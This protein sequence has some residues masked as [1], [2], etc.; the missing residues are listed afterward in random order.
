MKKILIIVPALIS[1]AAAQTKK[2]AKPAP[3]A[4]AQKNSLT[5]TDILSYAMGL[6]TAKYYKSQGI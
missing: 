1:I 4:V 5:S 3:K 6:Q 2:P